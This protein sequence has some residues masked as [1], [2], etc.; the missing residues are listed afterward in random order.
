MMLLSPLVGAFATENPSG[1]AVEVR[2]LLENVNEATDLTRLKLTLDSYIDPTI[3][4]NANLIR[5]Q[6][7]ET[8]VRALAGRNPTSG[9]RLAA[10]QRYLYEPG[11]W[12]DYRAYAYDQT[13]PLGT[14]IPNK[15]LSNYMD[16]RRGNCITM[17]FMMILLGD[18][19]G[20]DMTASTAPYHVFV[21]YTDPDIGRTVN[22]E[23]TSGGLPARDIWYQQNLPMTSTAIENGVYMQTLSRQ[24]MA[25]VMATVVVEH[26]SETGRYGEVIEVGSAILEFFPEYAYIHVRIGDAFGNLL[27]REFIQV[28][29]RPEMIPEPLVGRFNYLAYNNERAFQRAEELGWR[30]EDAGLSGNE[31]LAPE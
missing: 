8:T 11:L 12:N 25:A 9:A 1:T 28:Y 29:P 31:V 23:A 21:R 10:I 13:D 24:Q 20:L 7:I 18:R 27:D 14:Y 3:D 16:G 19:L 17:P 26:L 2:S 22:L 6:E 15:L 5:F 30:P 4:V